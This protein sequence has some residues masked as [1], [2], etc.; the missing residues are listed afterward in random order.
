MN[1]LDQRTQIAIMARKTKKALQQ[2]VGDNNAATEI[3][4]QQI[5]YKYLRLSIYT[6]N[7]LENPEYWEAPHYLS[8]ANSLRIDLQ[9]LTRQAGQAKP[10][11]LDQ[12]IEKIQKVSP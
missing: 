3:L 7:N 5:V 11:S 1:D 8:M 10:P 6:A 12:Y 9:E 4:I 2:F